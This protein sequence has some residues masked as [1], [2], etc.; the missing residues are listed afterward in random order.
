MVQ[1]TGKVQGY[2]TVQGP[3]VQDTGKVQEH[4]RVQE[5][6]RP[7]DVRAAWDWE[8]ESTSTGTWD[9]D[10]SLGGEMSR[11][12]CNSLRG[13]TSLGVGRDISA[14]ACEG[15]EYWSGTKGG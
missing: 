1:D 15:H 9:G 12:R 14:G 4:G 8:W 2:G 3:G 6:G 13:G 10:R 11:G 7:G 5:P